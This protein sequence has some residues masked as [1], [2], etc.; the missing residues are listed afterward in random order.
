MAHR[1]PPPGDI[2]MRP[3]DEP[4]FIVSIVSLYVDKSKS[5]SI[6]PNKAPL[7]RT[8]HVLIVKEIVYGQ[9]EIFY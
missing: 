6:W 3:N 1:I 4:H 8:Y 2:S 7:L 5:V 9:I